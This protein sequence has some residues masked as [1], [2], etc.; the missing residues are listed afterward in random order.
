[1]SPGAG[2]ATGPRG[3]APAGS[4]SQQPPHRAAAA[5]GFGVSKWRPLPVGLSGGPGVQRRRFPQ[6]GSG[7]KLKLTLC[8]SETAASVCGVSDPWVPRE[9]VPVAAGGAPGARAGQG[10]APCCVLALGAR[11][12]WLRDR[13]P[14]RWEAPWEGGRRC[15]PFA[16]ERE[17]RGSPTARCPRFASLRAGRPLPP[18]RA[19]RSRPGPGAGPSPKRFLRRAGSRSPVPQVDARAQTCPRAVSYRPRALGNIALRLSL[20]LHHRVLVSRRLSKSLMMPGWLKPLS[21]SQVTQFLQLPLPA[22]IKTLP[23]APVPPVQVTGA[24]QR[25]LS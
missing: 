12:A 25:T 3:E 13:G 17:P 6:I 2:G 15:V 19:L 9:G 16:A 21:E 10:R 5:G 24:L 18:P 4:G 20:F 23:A 22:G 14:L 7:K 1:M 11:A 8:V